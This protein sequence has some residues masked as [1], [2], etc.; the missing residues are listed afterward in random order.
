MRAGAQ[1]NE[2][3]VAVNR[4]FLVGQIV[5]V[6]EL[7]ALVSEDFLCFVDAHDLAHERL[8]CLDDFGHLLLDGPEVVGGDIVRK[9]EIVEVAVVGRRAEG[10]LRAGIELLHGFRHDVGAGVAHDVERLRAF[11]GDNLNGCPIRHGRCEVDQRAVNL[12]GQR[13]LRK[14]RADGSRNVGD[15]RAGSKLFYRAIG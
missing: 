2:G 10:D 4:D 9:L 7:E 13:S 1:V 14:A 5:D 3:P 15:G 6:L 8:V 11:R 12:A